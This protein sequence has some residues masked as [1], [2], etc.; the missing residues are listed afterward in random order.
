MATNKKY[1][2]EE[3]AQAI[4]K[5]F[6][7]LPDEGVLWYRGDNQNSTKEAGEEAGV[8]DPTGYWRVSFRDRYYMFHRVCWCIHHGSWP[9]GVID[10]IDRNPSNNKISN[11]RDVTNKVNSN[12]RRP[13]EDRKTLSGLYRAGDYWY[14]DIQRGG[15][16]AKGR[17]SVC[18]GKVL[19]ERAKFVAENR[20]PSK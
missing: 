12:N 15:K 6:T 7:Y 16:R 5:Y 1:E 17:G 9:K 19:K 3:T 4:A 18:L 13:Y 10:H 11:L 14:L 8:M 2:T 20:S